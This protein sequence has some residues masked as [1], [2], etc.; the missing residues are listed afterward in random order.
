MTLVCTKQSTHPGKKAQNALQPIKRKEA[1]EKKH[2]KALTT[3]PD[4]MTT[5]EMSYTTCMENESYKEFGFNSAYC[6]LST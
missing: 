3:I 4:C 5:G 2:K 1:T 6:W